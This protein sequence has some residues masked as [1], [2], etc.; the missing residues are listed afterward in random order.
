MFRPA[1]DGDI[2]GAAGESAA[3]PVSEAE[4]RGAPPEPAAGDAG[5][6][7]DV[8]HGSFDHSMVKD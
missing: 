7:Q 6:F 3:H 5:L 2:E 4:Q 8:R 1:F